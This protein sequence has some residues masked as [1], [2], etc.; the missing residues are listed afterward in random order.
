MTDNKVSLKFIGY[1]KDGDHVEYKV[2]VKDLNNETWQL[3][4]RYSSLR[5][6]Y[7]DLRDKFEAKNLPDFPPKKY[8]GGMSDNFISQRQKALEN[9]FNTVLKTYRYDELDALKAFIDSK[10][11]PKPVPSPTNVTQNQVAGQHQ[12]QPVLP[13]KQ[14]EKNKL[15]NLEK[16][17]GNFKNEFFDLNDTFNP[18]DEDEMRKRKSK[19]PVNI[20][21]GPGKSTYDLPSG[22]ES[23][24][25]SIQDKTLPSLNT[26]INEDIS[27][28]LDNIAQGIQGINILSQPIV[29]NLD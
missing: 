8:W 15:I 18:P 19:Y 1:E 7:R 6:I 16:V 11:Q 9:F 20:D 25:I 22:N 21:I 23:N 27:T 12:V 4:A 24:L 3:L 5:Q 2:I 14:A 17:I 13:D 29:V 26:K 28:T 10:R